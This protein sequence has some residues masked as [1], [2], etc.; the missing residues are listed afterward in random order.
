MRDLFSNFLLRVRQLNLK[1]WIIIVIFGLFVISNSAY[2]SGIPGLLG[3]EGDE[4]H[5]VYELIHKTKPAIQGERSYIGVWIDYLRMPFIVVF[6]HNTFSLRIIMLLFSIAFFWIAHKVLLKYFGEI[7]GLFGLVVIAFSPIYWSEMR[8]GWAISLLPFF[9]FL[10]I[11]LIR[12]KTSWSPLMAGLVAGFGI[13]THILFLPVLSAIIII[14]GY[15]QIVLLIRRFSF[16]K[17]R[18]LLS[19]FIVFLI[20]FWAVFCIQYVNLIINTNDQGNIGKTA[21]LFS[22]R[23]NELFS[24]APRILS[25]SFF[26]AQYTARTFSDSASLIITCILFLLIIAGLVFGKHRYALLGWIIGFGINY[27]ILVYMIEYYA[28]RYF[29][30]ATLCVWLLAGIGLGEIFNR[31]RNKKIA[32]VSIVPLAGL[33]V[34]VNATLI[35][36]PFLASGGSNDTFPIIGT[37]RFENSSSRIATAELVGCVSSLDQIFSNSVHIRNRLYYWADGNPRISVAKR[38]QDVQWLISYRMPNDKIT[39]DEVC[40]YLKNFRVNPVTDRREVDWPK[41]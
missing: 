22:T 36:F 33:L 20:G 25:G 5:N 17:V 6:G 27:F 9:A 2:L 24:I 15:N 13:S 32:Y 19:N 3:D 1:Q 39:P 10:T 34:C 28:I 30:V 31:L 11:Y 8:V 41:D 4:G 12:K 16:Q 14:F 37:S 35:I 26:I 21:R 29:I 18:Q 38:K 40:P 7:P 23:L